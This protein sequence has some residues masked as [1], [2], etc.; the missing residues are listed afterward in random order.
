MLHLKTEQ[1]LL[2]KKDLLIGSIIALIMGSIFVVVGGLPLIVT[3][4]PG[5]V[6]VVGIL[7]FLYFKKTPIPSSLSFMPIYFLTLAWQFI[8]LSEEFVTG[9]YNQFPVLYGQVAY[10]HEKFLMINMFSYS[11]FTLACILVFTKGLRFLIVPVLF[12]IVYGAIGN[13]VAHTWWVTYLGRYFP[14]FYTAQLY[15]L[16]GP[17]ALQQILKSWKATILSIIGFAVILI[18]AITLSI[19]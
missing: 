19:Q 8:H 6:V 15:W 13:A 7:C 4:I 5:L 2:E 14:G 1:Q 10:S 11:L 18:P 9:F 3:F 12:F 16:L 17:L